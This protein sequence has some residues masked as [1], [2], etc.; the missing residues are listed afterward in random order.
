MSSYKACNMTLHLPSGGKSSFH[1]NKTQ[2]NHSAL[3]KT[4]L[5]FILWFISK[6][7]YSHSKL[8]LLKFYNL[9]LENIFPLGFLFFFLFEPY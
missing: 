8:V 6:F 7:E 4:I 5:S 3:R 9:F 1:S 2:W